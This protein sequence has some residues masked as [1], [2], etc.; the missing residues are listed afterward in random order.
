MKPQAGRRP[1]AVVV[2]CSAGGLQALH[3]LLGGLAGPLPVPMVVVCHSGSED[4]RLFCE[5]LGSRS[6]LPVVEAEE[7]QLPASGTIYVAPSGYHLLVE[8]DGRFALSV[9]PRV[10][11]SRPSIDVLFESAAEVWHEHLLAVLLTGA[12]SDGA[13][14]CLRIRGHG[15]M[16]IVQD[17]RTAQVPMMPAAALELAGADYCLPLPEIPKLLEALCS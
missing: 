1:Q 4:M 10:S 12:N 3:T 16:V 17:P 8:R 11:F 5:L 13:E 15:G 6:G 2:G 9:D 14:G 7:R